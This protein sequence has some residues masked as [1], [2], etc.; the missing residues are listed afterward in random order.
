MYMYVHVEDDHV[1]FHGQDFLG[2]FIDTFSTAQFIFTI[3]YE[4][5]W[6]TQIEKL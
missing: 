3:E 2:L 4:K 1:L 6:E 5:G